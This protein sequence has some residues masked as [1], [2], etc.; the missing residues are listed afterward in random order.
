V[1]ISGGE[2]SKFTLDFYQHSLQYCNSLFNLN[3]NIM[4]YT[5]PAGG[6]QQ[7]SLNDAATMTTFYR[8]N[9]STIL[10][11]SYSSVLCNS[12]TFNLED[13]NT[14]L[15]ASGAAGMRIYYGMDEN[16]NVHAILVAVDEEGND[17]LPEENSGLNTDPIVIIEQGIRCPP[18]CPDSSPLNS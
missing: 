16:Y 13:V 3:P 2:K 11:T 5:L 10:N 17:I 1:K 12:E 6:T 7:I 4:S 15:A 9:K 18:T 8:N 14:M